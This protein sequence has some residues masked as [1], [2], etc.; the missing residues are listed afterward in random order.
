MNNGKTVRAEIHCPSCDSDIQHNHSLEA[1]DIPPMTNK[2]RIILP[3]CS[4]CGR[5]LQL[6]DVCGNIAA[7][8][9]V[10][11]ITGTTGAGKTALGQLIERKSSYVFIDGDAI[12][13]RVNYFAKK[14]PNMRVDYYTSTIETMMILCGLGYN[15]IIG[16]II[17]NAEILELFTHPLAEY[18]ITPTFRVLVP[19]REVCLSRDLSREC[20][21]AG[22]TW[23]DAWY[24]EMC[25]F[26]LTHPSA[27]IDTSN[28]MLEETFSRHF[29]KLL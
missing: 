11:L 24:G 12:Q 10:L 21:T 9:K 25:M 18:G 13:K 19:E 3:A 16:Y 27:C 28:E 7:D 6:A 14:K 4:V 26:L 1:S 8:R 20:W 5:G 15:V 29:A 2:S 23:I 17:N 22:A